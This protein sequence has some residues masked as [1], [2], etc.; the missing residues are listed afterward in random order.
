MIKYF[1]KYP[2][3]EGE[4]EKHDYWQAKSGDIIPAGSGE[5]ILHHAN[6]VGCKKVKLFLCSRDIQVGDE[7]Q[8]GDGELCKIPNEADLRNAKEHGFFKILGEI[9][10][11]ATWVKEGDDFDE[12]EIEFWDKT[13]DHP[14]DK[15]YLHKWLKE[16][17]VDYVLKYFYFKILGPCKHFH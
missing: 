7:V 17:R 14:T 16:G 9:S 10:P 11:E 13:E 8:N 6:E 3:V 1:V 5:R 2:P 12:E 4:I 15:S